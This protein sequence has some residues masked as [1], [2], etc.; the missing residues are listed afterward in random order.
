MTL[1]TNREEG[2]ISGTK[3]TS[4]QGLSGEVGIVIQGSQGTSGESRTS[5]MNKM[6]GE[7]ACSGHSKSQVKFS[8]NSLCNFILGKMML[9]YNIKFASTLIFSNTERD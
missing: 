9:F 3:G 1:E 2:R 7:E 4:T 6:G 5:E 8:G